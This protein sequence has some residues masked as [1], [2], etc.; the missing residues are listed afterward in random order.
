[1]QRTARKVLHSCPWRV[2]Y[3]PALLPDSGWWHACR[4]WLVH[5]RDKGADAAKGEGAGMFAATV[6][7]GSAGREAVVADIIGKVPENAPLGGACLG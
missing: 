6:F 1:M 4:R 3:R 7:R 2:I 5:R